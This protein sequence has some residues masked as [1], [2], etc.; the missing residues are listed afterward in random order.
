MK[1]KLRKSIA[2]LLAIT[3]TLSLAA[4]RGGQNG[5]ETLPGIVQGDEIFQAEFFTVDAPIQVPQPLAIAGDTLYILYRTAEWEDGIGSIRTDGTGFTSFWRSENRQF[6]SDGYNHFE[7]QFIL[8]QAGLPNGGLA[9]LIREES[10]VAEAWDDG[11]WNNRREEE[12]PN[13][14]PEYNGAEYDGIYGEEEPVGSAPAQTAMLSG[15]RIVQTTEM[16]TVPPIGDAVNR[17]FGMWHT[18]LIFS[19]DGNLTAEIELDEQMQ[20]VGIDPHAFWTQHMA[21]FADGRLLFTTEDGMFFVIDPVTGAL[22]PLSG[23]EPGTRINQFA[24]TTAGQVV[25]V[26]WDMETFEETLYVFEPVDGQKTE[27]ESVLDEIAVTRLITPWASGSADLY[28]NTTQGVMSLD[29]Q[30][31]Q[32]THL[33][34]WMDIHMSWGADFVVAENGDLYLFEPNAGEVTNETLVR[35]FRGEASA[36]DERVDLTLGTLFMTHS[37]QQE[38]IN[39]N[40]TNP[41]YRIHIREYVDWAAGVEMDEA[42]R[43]LNA[44][45]ITGNAPD[46]LV[47]DNLSFGLYAGRGFLAD[48]GAMIDADPEISRS[49]FVENVFNLM[50]VNGRLYT[51]VAEFGLR[52]LTGKTELVGAEMGWT[53]DEFLA[54]AAALPEG[55]RVF[56]NVSRESFMEHMLGGNLAQFINSETGE[57]RFDT[58]LFEAYLEFASTLPT[59]AQIWGDDGMGMPGDFTR[60][61]VLEGDYDG[62]WI[63]PFATGQVLL[64]EQ[65]LNGFRDLIWVRQGQFQADVTFKGFPNDSGVGAVLMP[66]TVLAI[67][68]AS[69]H[70]DAAWSFVRRTLTESFQLEGT[71]AFPTN[72]AVQQIRIEEAMTPPEWMQDH[73]EEYSIGIAP[74]IWPPIDGIEETETASQADIDQILALIAAVDQVQMLNTTINDIIAEETLPYFEGNRPAAEAARIIQSRVQIYVNENR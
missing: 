40:R 15:T 46:I 37:L 25:V 53:M 48:I 67:S 27:L 30:A 24:I 63:S 10:H 26:T 3:L 59:N 43:R 54:A 44:D 41:H 58:P 74:P 36:A 18:V 49:D 29:L 51:A 16:P 60:R 52:T 31:G 5:T 1:Q 35:L 20:A 45:I 2:L 32:V 34:D 22:A 21:A 61:V 8:A 73:V 28:V 57:V 6:E 65:F 66:Q 69:Q 7:N 56:E 33:F 70:Q 17:D 64:M 19:A 72:L 47:L 39:F 14:S 68:A 42:V 12:Y 23:W 13:D 4:C 9:L 38:V 55:A 11:E 50:E 71:F 62:Q